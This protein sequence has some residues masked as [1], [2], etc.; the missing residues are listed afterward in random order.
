MKSG[1]LPDAPA[2]VERVHELTEH[3]DAVFLPDTTVAG[4]IL[5]LRELVSQAPV[6]Y[7]FIADPDRCLLGVFT[8]RE[9]L[10]A[11]PRQTLADIALPS[12]FYLRADMSLQE[13]MQETVARHYPVYPVCDDQGTLLGVVRG[14]RLF[15]AQTDEISA[16]A[17][18][19]QGVDREERL[20]TPWPRSLLL[21]HPWLQLNLLTAFTAAAVVGVFQDTLDRIIVLAAFLPVLAGQS[22]NTGCQALAVTLRAMT[23]GETRGHGTIDI[24]RKE[25]ILGLVNGL[26]IGLVAGLAMWWY[27]HSHL[28]DQA[29]LLAFTVWVSMAAACLI[30]SVCGAT[31]PL[32]LLRA[33]TDPATASGIFL[34]TLTDVVSMGVFLGMA[35]LLIPG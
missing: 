12:P 8:F 5:R 35:S 6:T 11:D 34:T 15:E 14:Q 29:G 1:L 20:H 23:L 22:G 31:I 28:P 10:F 21:R 18:L 9:L 32:L 16:Q 3:T 27:A 4:A 17:G 19:L 2:H 24:L 25:A 7:G 13:A 33:G 30:S 26:L